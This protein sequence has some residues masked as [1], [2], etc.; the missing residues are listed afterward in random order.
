MIILIFS[1]IVVGMIFY[2]R[3]IPV[4]GIKS[5]EQED[6]SNTITIVDIRDFNESYKSPVPGALTIPVAYLKR[7]YQDIPSMD[8]YLVASSK[9]E[10]NMGIRYLQKKGY[11][12]RGYSIADSTR[13]LL[14]EKK[15]M[16]LGNNN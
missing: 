4:F 7:N 15:S 6:I 1:M 16:S 9:L 2:K 3:Y 12:I 5:V 11:H 8:L 14:N 10:S 13:V